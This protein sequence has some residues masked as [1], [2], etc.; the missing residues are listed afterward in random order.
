MRRVE[1]QGRVEAPP[2]EV[3]AYLA[4]LDNLADWQSGIVT[5]ERVDAGEMQVGSSAR[6]ARQLMG[7]RLEV[8]LTVSHYEPPSRLGI[9]SEASGVKVAAMLDLRPLDG[10]DATDLLFMMEIRGSLMTAFMEPMIASAA[11]G[12]IDASIGRVQA[13]FATGADPA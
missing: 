6:V 4:D 10:G 11:K 2:D 1:G 5:A 8:P 3:F 13:R 12:D 7:Q 9:T